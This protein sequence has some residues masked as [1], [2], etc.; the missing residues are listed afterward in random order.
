MWLLTE[1][2]HTMLWAGLNQTDTGYH[3]FAQFSLKHKHTPVNLNVSSGGDLVETVPLH[4]RNIIIIIIITVRK[5][6]LISFIN[7]IS[8]ISPPSAEETSS[9]RDINTRAGTCLTAY[10]FSLNRSLQ[11]SLHLISLVEGKKKCFVPETGQQGQISQDMKR[12]WMW[13]S[14]TGSTS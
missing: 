12:F 3:S 4:N 1:Q 13:G 11:S 8:Q 9:C 7:L 14:G 5:F 10:S 6:G 2:T